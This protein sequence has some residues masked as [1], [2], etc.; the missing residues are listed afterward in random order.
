MRDLI[1]ES[2]FDSDGQMKKKNLPNEHSYVSVRIK[3]G[4]QVVRTRE[5]IDPE[6]EGLQERTVGADFLNDSIL[7]PTR[8]LRTRRH[9]AY[10]E[11]LNDDSDISDFDYQ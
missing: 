2:V 3:I 10:T 8:D 5:E 1:H 11:E 6:A 9:V 7:E 4:R